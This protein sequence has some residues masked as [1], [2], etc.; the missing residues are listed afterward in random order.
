MIE[1]SPD[2][3]AVLARLKALK[4]DI[5]REFLIRKR[6]GRPYT[7]DGFSAIWQRLMGKHVKAGG[8]GSAFMTF[9][10][11]RRR[12]CYAGGGARPPGPRE[13]RDDEAPLLARAHESQAAKLKI[14]N[15]RE[16]IQHLETRASIKL[17][18]PERFELPTSWFVARRSIQLS[19]GRT[20]SK[21]ADIWLTGDRSSTGGEG[22]IARGL[23]AA[24][25]LRSASGP[26]SASLPA[27]PSLAHLPLIL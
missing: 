12:R 1:H 3:D 18:R 26:P 19:Y 11:L 5:P 2:L 14:F 10:G 25:S 7:E 8:P 21:Y 17:A 6:N 15:T 20:L 4:P 24:Q 13:R 22:G 9:A 16:N 27:S 23:A